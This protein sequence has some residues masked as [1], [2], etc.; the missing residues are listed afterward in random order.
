MQ[1][2]KPGESKF[3]VLF[4]STNDPKTVSHIIIKGPQGIG[5]EIV[6]ILPLGR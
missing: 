4:T 5:T 1:Y 6:L 3:T 2:E